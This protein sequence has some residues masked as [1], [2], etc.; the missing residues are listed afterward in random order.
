MWEMVSLS[1]TKLLA[2][3]N[4]CYVSDTHIYCRGTITTCRTTVPQ[5]VLAFLRYSVG[6]C[7]AV[8]DSPE[9]TLSC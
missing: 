8:M 2:V 3:F 5:T 7:V 9:G 4:H 1:D 6:D